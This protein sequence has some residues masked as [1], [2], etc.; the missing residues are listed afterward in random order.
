MFD[1]LHKL[2]LPWSLKQI[3]WATPVLFCKVN[4]EPG[5]KYW[6]DFSVFFPSAF[7]SLPVPVTELC[8]RHH[9]SLL[10]WY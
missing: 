7:A 6:E 10:E 8:G 5:L 2:T 9:A 1:A 4:L 3:N